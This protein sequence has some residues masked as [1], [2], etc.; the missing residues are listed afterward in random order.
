M[1]IAY[2]SQSALS[3]VDFSYIKEAQKLMDIDYYI[4][5]TPSQR[6]K[7]AINLKTLPDSFGII[8]ANDIKELQL[9]GRIVDL[10]KVF[11]I[12]YTA[13][14]NH[15]LKKVIESYKVYKELKRKRYDVIHLT[16]PVNYLDFFMYRLKNKIVLT[17][18]DPF[19]HSSQVKGIREFERKRAF[20]KCD[21]FIILNS[22]QKDRFIHTYDLNKST[23]H[24]YASS[25]SCYDYLFI[26]K[27][28]IREPVYNQILFFGQIFA[29]KGVDYLLKAMVKVHEVCPNAKL[30][31]AGS[32]KYWFDIKPFKDLD[33]IDIRNRFI[34]DAELVR[35]VSSSAFVVVPYIDATQSG[36]IMTAYTFNRPCIATN[37]G[38]LPEMVKDGYNGVLVEPND[39]DALASAMI[40]LLDSSETVQDYSNNI[41]NEYKEG[42]KS[43]LS[44]STQFKEIYQNV[45]NRNN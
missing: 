21:N 2:I 11:V 8:K 38:A 28:E 34:P 6:Q 13:V 22:V 23:K 1:K 20:R 33:Y 36:V 5:V 24:V 32:G 29:H 41:K 7:A 45:Y 4:Q 9:F 37:V 25:L 19:P 12:N 17:V 26:H 42:N 16:W 27:K 18:H 44:I 15:Q 35:L 30:I 10:S 31:V 14:N 39:S 3:D 40:K 43:W